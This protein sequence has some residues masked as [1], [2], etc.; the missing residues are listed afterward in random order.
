MM[1]SAKMVPGYFFVMFV[2]HQAKRVFIADRTR[3][4]GAFGQATEI[5]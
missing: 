5:V 1:A 2:K 3:T 4:K